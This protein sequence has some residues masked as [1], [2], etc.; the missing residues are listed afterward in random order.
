E[1]RVRH[2]DLGDTHGHACEPV[3]PDVEE[4]CAHVQVGAMIS[5]RPPVPNPG[6][7][8]HGAAGTAPSPAGGG[9]DAYRT[10]RAPTDQGTHGPAFWISATCSGLVTTNPSGCSASSA[11]RCRTRSWSSSGRRV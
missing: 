2:A 1:R 9:W 6:L 4:G 10:V 7:V 11:R 3:L 8:G 5:W